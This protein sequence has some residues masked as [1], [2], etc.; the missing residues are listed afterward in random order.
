MHKLPSWRYQLSESWVKMAPTGLPGLG[1]KVHST[2]K[3]QRLTQAGIL[4][5]GRW[6]ILVCCPS[7]GPWTNIWWRA[8]FSIYYSPR[9]PW[10]G[11]LTGHQS[12]IKWHL[13]GSSHKHQGNRHVHEFFSGR[14]WSPERSRG[15]EGRCAHQPPWFLQSVQ[16]TPGYV[17]DEKP[18]PWTFK[19]SN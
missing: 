5:Q 7:T 19:V 4:F 10:S 11:S 2:C 8:V 6:E 13:L 9:A 12:Q 17:S 16:L 3:S 14:Y 15:R 18:F 1:R